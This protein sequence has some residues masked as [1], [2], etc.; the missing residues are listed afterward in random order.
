MFHTPVAARTANAGHL[1]EPPRRGPGHR[2]V[3]QR[4]DVEI[5]EYLGR[6][7]EAVGLELRLG[8]R[9]ARLADQF[10]GLGVREVGDAEQVR[11][12]GADLG[13]DRAAREAEAGAVRLRGLG[14]RP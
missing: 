9:A 13:D 14:N 2:E 8:W 3:G 12:G 10:V 1:V 11:C 4:R 7:E 5:C 6:R